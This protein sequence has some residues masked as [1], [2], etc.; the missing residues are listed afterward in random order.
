[1]TSFI[2]SQISTVKLVRRAAQAMSELEDATFSYRRHESD[3]I[4]LPLHTHH[5]RDQEAPHRTNHERTQDMD[6]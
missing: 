1:M 3:K 6:W 2:K 4:H 5:E